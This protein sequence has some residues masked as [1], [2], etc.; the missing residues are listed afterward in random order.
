MWFARQ[1]IWSLFMSR[2]PVRVLNCLHSEY[3]HPIYLKT[4]IYPIGRHSDQY[5]E[6]PSDNCVLPQNSYIQ[7]VKYKLYICFVRLVNPMSWFIYAILQMD[8]LSWCT[9]VRTEVNLTHLSESEK[10]KALK[11]L[12]HKICWG[13]TPSPTPLQLSYAT[14]ALG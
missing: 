3:L 1:V 5:T 7:I 14:A 12:R 11:I 6:K 4:F 9:R 10:Q 13:L 2:A 8:T